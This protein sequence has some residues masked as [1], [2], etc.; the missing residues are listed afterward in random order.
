[1]NLAHK[2]DLALQVHVDTFGGDLHDRIRASPVT[3]DKNNI[4]FQSCK[5][6]D[7]SAIHSAD[8]QRADIDITA[9]SDTDTIHRRM[10]RSN[11]IRHCD[12]TLGVVP[13]TFAGPSGTRGRET[14][15]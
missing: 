12:I 13:D 11:C 6:R 5:Q 14:D 15:I 7:L 1:M 3:D 10:S 8:R 2:F 4:V 9:V